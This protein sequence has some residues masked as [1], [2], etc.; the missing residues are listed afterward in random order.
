LKTALLDI[1][2]HNSDWQKIEYHPLFEAFKR[3]TNQWLPAGQE[4]IHQ[5]VFIA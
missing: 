4:N 1:E 3:N 2:T 5:F